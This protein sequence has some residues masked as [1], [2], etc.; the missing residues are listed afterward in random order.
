MHSAIEDYVEECTNSLRAD[1]RGLRV[2]VAPL[3][4][5]LEQVHRFQLSYVFESY[6]INGRS[7][8]TKRLVIHADL[9]TSGTRCLSVSVNTGDRLV[10]IY[11]YGN[12]ALDSIGGYDQMMEVARV[13]TLLGGRYVRC[14]R[15]TEIPRSKAPWVLDYILSC[16][17]SRRRLI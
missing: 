7:H 14:L 15:I 10:S 5:L 11:Y 3:L 12:R 2:R 13:T 6:C 16:H 9:R 8:S 1:I 17:S 4:C